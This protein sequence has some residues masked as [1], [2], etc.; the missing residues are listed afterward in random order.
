[1]NTYHILIQLRGKR[2]VLTHHTAVSTEDAAEV[3][4]SMLTDEDKDRVLRA[5]EVQE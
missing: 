4:L 1:M 3:A 5:V 2:S